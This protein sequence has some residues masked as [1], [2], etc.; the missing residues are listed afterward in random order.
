LCSLE[1]A[2]LLPTASTTGDE[3]E[4]T[5]IEGS[6]FKV[7]AITWKG[8][9]PG[10]YSKREWRNEV[11]KPAWKELGEWFH[12]DRLPIRFT[13]KAKS[14][15]SLAPR[16]GEEP[17]VPYKAI[18]YSYTGRKMKYKGHKKPFVWS[19]ETERDATRIRDVRSTS[20]GVKVVLHVRKLNFKHPKSSIRMNEEIRRVAESEYPMIQRKFNAAVQRRIDA[21]KRARAFK[22]A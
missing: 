14:L 10:A 11:L 17:G 9:I 6:L 13:N 4:A 21:D 22:G 16:R 19:G 12:K 2:S 18:K 15:L 5:G 1:Q 3:M 7:K 8:T 20:N